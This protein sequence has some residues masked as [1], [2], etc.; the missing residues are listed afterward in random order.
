MDTAT[1]AALKDLTDKV[2]NLTTVEA[3]LGTV[4]DT[5]SQ[6]IS[7]FSAQLAAAVASAGSTADP[8]L[9][10]AL[11]SLGATMDTAA[12]DLTSKKSELSAALVANT[13]TAPAS[14]T[15]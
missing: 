5:A 14:P 4:V 13:P 8:A 15:T 1:S 11:T 7:G 12:A 10:S 2:T 3:G 9:V 6:V